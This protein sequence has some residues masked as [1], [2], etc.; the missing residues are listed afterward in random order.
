MS[1][2]EHSV[3]KPKFPLKDRLIN[4]IYLNIVISYIFKKYGGQ[5]YEGDYG[6]KI[7]EKDPRK[8][9]NIKGRTITLAEHI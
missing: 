8:K 6:K 9:K 2:Q 5:L 1:V 3:K 4:Y 7:T